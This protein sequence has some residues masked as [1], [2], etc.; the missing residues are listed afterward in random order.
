MSWMSH[1]GA[2]ARQAAQRFGSLQIGYL[3]QTLQPGIAAALLVQQQPH[4]AHYEFCPAIIQYFSSVGIVGK[5]QN[6]ASSHLCQC[7]GVHI[8]STLHMR[9]KRAAP[10]SKPHGSQAFISGLLQL[11]QGGK[12]IE[13][14]I[15]HNVLMW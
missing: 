11:L 15:L 6:R 1:L 12:G 10:V 7:F 3:A 5:C 2:H 13:R 8:I 9:G 14:K 4:T